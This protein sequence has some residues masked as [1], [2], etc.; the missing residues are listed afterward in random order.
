MDVAVQLGKIDAPREIDA[1]FPVQVAEPTVST[2][3]A[4]AARATAE[5]IAANIMVVVGTKKVPIDTAKIRPWITFSTTADG[6]YVPVVDTSKVATLLDGL[7][8]KIDQ[9]AV[10]ASFR[11]SGSKVTGVTASKDGYAVD[12]AATAKQVEALL[13]ARAV[14]TASTE[15]RPAVTVTKPVLTTAQAEAAAP[16][17]KKISSWTTYFPISDHNGYGANIWIP[18]LTIDGTVVG[19]RETFDFWKAIGTVSRAKGYKQGAAIIDGHSE[20]QGALAGGICSCSTT[21][22]NAA[23]RAG[24]DMGARRNHYYYI[25]RYPLGLDATVFISASGAKQTMSWTNDTDYPVLIRGF[26]IRSGSSGYVRFELYSVPT[27]RTVTLGKPVVK[28]VKPAHDSIQ[29]TTSLAPGAT[30]RIEYPVD[31]KQVWRTVTV[32]D[33]SGKVIHTETYYSN[34]SRVTGVLLVGRAAAATD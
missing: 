27:G 4:T 21:L 6:G 7:A 22:F 20:P 33:A 2:E 16:K 3:E 32:R 17:M 11:T 31:G 15:I 24:F 25:D 26:K 13:A 28:N 19:P 1:T 23:L 9:K 34:Y 8:A 5:R 10:N 30:K 29:Y 18:A 14:G 12:L